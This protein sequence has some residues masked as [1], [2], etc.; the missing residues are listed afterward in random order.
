MSFEAS[1]QNGGE[2]HDLHSSPMFKERK[3]LERGFVH[4]NEL[5]RDS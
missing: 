5:E 3:R 2:S 4:E 1:L